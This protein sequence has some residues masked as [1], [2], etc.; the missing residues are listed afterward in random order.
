MD[1]VFAAEPIEWY[2]GGETSSAHS[3]DTLKPLELPYSY[4]LFCY[5]R[6]N[7]PVCTAELIELQ[8]YHQKFV[9][10]GVG[11]VAASTDSPESHAKFFEDHEAF[12]P[13][14]VLNI[15]YPIITIKEH[16]VLFQN[17]H[18]LFNEFGYCKRTALVVRHG[19]LYNVYQ[20]DN[21]TPRSMKTLLSL[22]Q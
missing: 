13:S 2:Y 5:P 10:A 21:D 16:Q 20:T 9:D 8:K 12:P 19:K 18:L 11:V 15:E 4:V 14:K 6:D 1:E 17:K 3:P 7:T 22:V